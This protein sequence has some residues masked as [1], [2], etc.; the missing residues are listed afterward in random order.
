VHG[1]GPVDGAVVG[2]GERAGGG[3]LGVVRPSRTRTEA[4]IGARLDRGDD[5]GRSFEHGVFAAEQE[6]AGGAGDDVEAHGRT[7]T[8]GPGRV[9]R[10]LSTPCVSASARRTRGASLAAHRALTCGPASMVA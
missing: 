10:V 3:A 2:L 1:K 9:T 7:T 5:G 6:L 4:G 8:P